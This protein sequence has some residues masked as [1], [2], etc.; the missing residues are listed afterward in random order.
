LKV[1]KMLPSQIDITIISAVF[2]IA[3]VFTILAVGVYTYI[4]GGH[5]AVIDASAITAQIRII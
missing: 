4:S 3:F 5:Q 1:Q 2:V